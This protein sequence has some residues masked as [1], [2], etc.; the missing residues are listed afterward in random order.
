MPRKSQRIAKRYKRALESPAQTMHRQEQNGASMAKKR[1]LENPA[2]TLRRQEKDRQCVAKKREIESPTDTLCRQEKDRQRIAKKRALETPSETV[3]RQQKNQAYMAKRRS[4]NIFVDSAVST[5]L[6]KAKMG[7]DFVCTSCH[8]LMYKANVVPCNKSKY[9]KAS[10][11]L[12]DQVFEHSYS[13]SDGKQW[14]CK[15]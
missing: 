6:S 10:D 13:S 12:L 9:T 3:C 11:E 2:N 7:P 5:F 8:R 14:L 15:T 4:M 1:A